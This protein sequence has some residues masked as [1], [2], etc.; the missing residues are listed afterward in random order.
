MAEG[1]FFLFCEMKQILMRSISQTFSP[2]PL[3]LIGRVEHYLEEMRQRRPTATA[4]LEKK[5]NEYKRD[6]EL[7]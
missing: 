4:E 1:Q 3:E 2:P 5:F 6:L 7:Q